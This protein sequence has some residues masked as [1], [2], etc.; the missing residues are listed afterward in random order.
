MTSD[1]GSESDKPVKSRRSTIISAAL[2]VRTSP[3]RISSLHDQFAGLASHIG[4][5]HIRGKPA[6]TLNFHDRRISWEYFFEQPEICAARH[7]V[8]ARSLRTANAGFVAQASLDGL[9]GFWSAQPAAR[10]RGFKASER[11][12]PLAWNGTSRLSY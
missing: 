6:E 1:G 9:G 12:P 8:A 3:R 11:S 7:E 10:N 4:R 2:M 5:Q